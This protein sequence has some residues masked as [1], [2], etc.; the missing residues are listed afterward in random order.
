MFASVLIIGLSLIL[1]VY[2]FRYSCLLLLRDAPAELAAPQ[3]ELSARFVYGEVR[4]NLTGASDLGLLER[5]LQRDYRL[6]SFLMDHASTLGLGS[7]EY[8]MLALDFRM[9]QIWYRLTRSVFPASARQALAEMASV[10]DVLVSRVDAQPS[11]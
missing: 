4:R 3:T 5:A 10:L 6:L 1:L 9:M 7:L 11:A 2:W 8:R